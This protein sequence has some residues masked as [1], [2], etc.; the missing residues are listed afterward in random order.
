MASYINHKT[1]TTSVPYAQGVLGITQYRWSK[2]SKAERK[3]AQKKAYNKHT[4][5]KA[6]RRKKVDKN[7]AEKL[8]HSIF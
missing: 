2:M 3:K 8:L 6:K 4:R 5:L 1:K 7:W